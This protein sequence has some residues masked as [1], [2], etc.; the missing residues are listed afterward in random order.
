MKFEEFVKEVNALLK[1]TKKAGDVQI[2]TMLV[3][4]AADTK[5][6][7]I[8]AMLH[9]S[10]LDLADIRNMMGLPPDEDAEKERAKELGDDAKMERKR[11]G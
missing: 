7:D 8:Q 5:G 4:M 9:A 11:D 2:W 1:E 3:W 10:G 6:A